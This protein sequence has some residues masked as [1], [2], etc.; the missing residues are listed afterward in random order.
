MQAEPPTTRPLPD[1]TRV[2]VVGGGV[3]GLATSLFL[4]WHGVAAV[5]VERRPGTSVHP[6]AWGWYPRTLE[7]LRTVGIEDDVLRESAG[8]V[9]HTLNATVES[10][11]GRTLRETTI[12][13]GEDVGDVS[14]VARIVSLSQ[15]RLEPIML[16][17]ARELGVDVRFATELVDLAEHGD[18]GGGVTARLRDVGTGAT[19]TLA[20]DYVVAADGAHSALRERLGIARHGRG[21]L[22]HQASILFRADLEGPLGGRRF[23]ICQVKNDEV[24]GVLGH[25]DSLRQGTLIVTYDP[26]RGE[27]ADDITTERATELVHAAIGDPDL[28]VEIRSVLP[29]EMA[30]LVAERFAAGRVFLVGDAAHVVPPVGGYGANTGVHDAHNLAWK[31]AAT[32]SGQAGPQLLD[33]YEQERLPVA[34]YVVEQAGT[35]LAVR[36][37]FASDEQRAALADTLTVT[38]GYRYDSSAVVPDDPDRGGTPFAVPPR[39]LDGRPG[40]RAPHLPVRRSGSAISLLDLYGGRPVLVAGP[41]GGEWTAAAA[42][43]AAERG[44][45]LEVHRA[46]T[47]FTE[48]GRSFAAAHDITGSGAVLVRPDG[49]V[50]WRARSLPAAGAA[51]TVGAA[52]DRMLARP[53][54]ATR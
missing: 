48:T 10:L 28:P 30:A 37:G 8:F 43:A 17:R 19:T 2:L 5:L 13:E 26:A 50:A 21:A 18:E 41:D 9:G 15:D 6:R 27:S 24:D 11:L 25:D 39:D 20:A 22:R 49:F 45:G 52:L 36:A 3:A 51:A 42:E 53:V 47:D 33:T 16:R 40:T 23:A 54:P 12:P 38:F 44:I 1:R 35:R 34:R 32:L 46:G 29:W 7:L 14:P 31:L 4:A